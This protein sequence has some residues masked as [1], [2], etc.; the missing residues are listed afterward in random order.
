M[1]NQ[2]AFGEVCG[3]QHPVSVF[4]VEN[5]TSSLAERDSTTGVEVGIAGSVP[6]N[7]EAGAVNGGQQSVPRRPAK[8]SEK[9]G[10]AYTTTAVETGE[11]VGPLRCWGKTEGP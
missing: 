3:Q 2:K 8:F 6:A 9:E 1:D 10:I 7:D 4:Q 11:A 5:S